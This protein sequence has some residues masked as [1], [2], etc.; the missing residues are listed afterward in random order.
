MRMREIEPRQLVALAE[1][2]E[3]DRHIRVAAQHIRI[4]A[5]VTHRELLEHDDIAREMP[6]LAAAAAALGD[7][8]VRNLGTVA[9]NVCWADPRANMAVALLASKAV[10]IAVDRDGQH[11]HIPLEHF[12]TGHRLNALGPRLLTAIEIPRQ[13]GARGS[14]LE[15]SRQTQDLALVNVAVV[16]G[17]QGTVIAVG[18]IDPTPVRLPELEVVAASPSPKALQAALADSLVGA[19]HEPPPDQFGTADYKL[20]LAATLLRQALANVDG[21]RHG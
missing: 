11:E 7:V 2:D 6:W 4:G 8:Q 14:Y 15:F 16:A 10:A 3:L 19:L 18:G 17:E 13:T 9:G 5:L 21:V 20:E 1:V 12:F